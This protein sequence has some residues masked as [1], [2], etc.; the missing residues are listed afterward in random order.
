MTHRYTRST[1]AREIALALLA[2]VFVVPVY[3]LVVASL[4]SQDQ[5]DASPLGLPRPPTATNYSQAWT[6]GAGFGGTSIPT[7]LATSVLITTSSVIVLVILGSLAGYVLGRRTSRMSTTLYLF[8]VLG[9]IIPFQMTIVPLYRLLNLLGLVGSR[10]GMV[11]IYSGL[12]MP[13]SVFLYTGFV[14]AIPPDY[15][16]A[17]LVDGAPR[18]WIF[19]RVVFPLLRPVTGTVAI[20]GGVFIWN[21]FF[22]PLVFL[23]GTTHQTLPVAIYSFVG[24]YLSQWGL[25]FAGVVIAITPVL[26]VYFAFQRYV[27]R[28]FA[29]GLKG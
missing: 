7:A 5:I 27:I 19:A 22:T 23:G 16:E 24:R 13:L 25:I 1:L 2:C 8:F 4:K 17:A 14:R 3:L 28:G 26:L 29:T 11:V 21:D 18:L 9:L 12:L 6:Q 20:L 15:E 10:S